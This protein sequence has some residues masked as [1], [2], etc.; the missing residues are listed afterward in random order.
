MTRE[1]FDAWN[2]A[3]LALTVTAAR[4][5]VDSPSEWAREQIKLGLCNGTWRTGS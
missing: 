3:N 5:C 4:P 1:E 2:A